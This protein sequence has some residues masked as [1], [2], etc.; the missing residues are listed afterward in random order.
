MWKGWLLLDP[1]TC[2]TARDCGAD[3]TL[4]ASQSGHA[5]RFG[6]KRYGGLG[7]WVEP[8][9]KDTL[10]AT[11]SRRRVSEEQLFP[12]KAAAPP[13]RNWAGRMKWSGSA[14]L[15][16][17][18]GWQFPNCRYGSR[19][20]AILPKLAPLCRRGA[21][22]HHRRPMQAAHGVVHSPIQRPAAAACVGEGVISSA[23]QL[24]ME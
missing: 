19:R 13:S 14:L 10:G 8:K 3:S 4:S 20:S 23:A 11:E 6:A 7:G 17:R 18:S 22:S 9:R 15:T 12:S 21:S 2:N 5:F 24:L 1:I 16:R